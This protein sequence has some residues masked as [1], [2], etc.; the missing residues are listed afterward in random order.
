MF[1][2]CTIP[3]R[4]FWGCVI[5]DALVAF[6]HWLSAPCLVTAS[7]DWTLTHDRGKVMVCPQRSSSMSVLTAKD[8]YSFKE[9]GIVSPLHIDLDYIARGQCREY[10]IFPWNRRCRISKIPR[11]INIDF[12]FFFFSFFS[13]CRK[14]IFLSFFSKKK[15][16]DE[17]VFAIDEHPCPCKFLSK[18]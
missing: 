1:Y 10:T 8:F 16:A 6:S 9:V 14:W 15:I 4:S 3:L 17:T 12:C 5:V 2:C 11:H 13:K 18:Q 7:G